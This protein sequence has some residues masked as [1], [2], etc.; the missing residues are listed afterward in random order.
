[1]SEQAGGM[2]SL[3]AFFQVGDSVT[4]ISTEKQREE[5]R[6]SQRPWS[7]SPSRS[8]PVGAGRGINKLDFASA[9]SKHLS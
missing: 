3:M 7:A 9:R 2:N 6:S 1:M 4:V 8:N 5:R